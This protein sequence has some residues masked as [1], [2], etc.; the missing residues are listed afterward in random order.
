MK[1]LNFYQFSVQTLRILLADSSLYKTGQDTPVNL[2]FLKTRARD[3]QKAA[4]AA[5]F[6]L[7]DKPQQNT[8]QCL[9]S[10]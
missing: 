6:V 4:A 7:D 5:S 10:G 1:H 9:H 2:T 3:L 8:A